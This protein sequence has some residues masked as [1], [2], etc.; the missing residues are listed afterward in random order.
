MIDMETIP[1]ETCGSPTPFKGTKRCNNCWEVE[2]RLPTYLRN[3]KGVGFIR[4]LMPKLDDWVDGKPDAWDYEA[5]L[6]KYKVNVQKADCGHYLCWHQGV[7]HV[8]TYNETHALKAA[9][10]FVELWLRGVTASFS[11]KIMDG[12]LFYLEAQDGKTCKTCK[13]YQDGTGDASG[14]KHCSCP[15]MAYG[16]ERGADPDGMTVECDEGWGMVPGPDF[17]CIHHQK[18]ENSI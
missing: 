5:V 4:S 18:S 14:A 7:M 16:Y 6:R 15:K 2:G 10:L 12:F 11:D 17:G 8:G 13:W 3:P 9:A 1:C